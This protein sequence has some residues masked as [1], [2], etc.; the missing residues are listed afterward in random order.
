M[1]T[2]LLPNAS[3]VAGNQYIT[4]KSRLI[5]EAFTGQNGGLNPSAIQAN[6]LDFQGKPLPRSTVAKSIMSE[7]KAQLA[8][9]YAVGPDSQTRKLTGKNVH[10]SMKGAAAG[11]TVPPIA[12]RSKQSAAFASLMYRGKK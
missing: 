8:R 6:G 10:P 2:L 3:D 5:A 12:D 4:D 9:N 7:N 1:G 11:G